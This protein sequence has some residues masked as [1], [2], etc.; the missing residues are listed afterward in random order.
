MNLHIKLPERG[1]GGSKAGPIVASVQVRPGA[2]WSSTRGDKL[3]VPRVENLFG[4]KTFTETSE[5]S[6][7]VGPRAASP[8]AT[9]R[10]SWGNA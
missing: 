1:Q 4:V 3:L 6:I 10:G 2:R 5:H 8:D 7:V 9:E